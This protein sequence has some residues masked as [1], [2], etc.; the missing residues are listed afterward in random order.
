MLY[1]F[2]EEEAHSGGSH[3]GT[4]FEVEWHQLSPL[5]SDDDNDDEDSLPLAQ[6][7]AR[8]KAIEKANED[9]KDKYIPPHAR[10]EKNRVTI[11]LSTG[12]SCVPMYRD[13]G[14]EPPKPEL[15]EGE[16]E[17]SREYGG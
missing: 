13:D 15:R 9:S 6:V 4:S 16:D 8:Q 2:V 7:R 14:Y 12:I 1:D 17:G 3:R 10:I 5:S 11:H